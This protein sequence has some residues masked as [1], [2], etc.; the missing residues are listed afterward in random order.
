[1]ALL[2]VLLVLLDDRS[3]CLSLGPFDCYVRVLA[4]TVQSAQNQSFLDLTNGNQRFYESFALLRVGLAQPLAE[5][6]KCIRKCD[7]Y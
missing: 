4:I 7:E 3:L 2:M 5:Y 1:M 6:G